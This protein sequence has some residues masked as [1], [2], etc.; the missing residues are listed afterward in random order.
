MHVCV[1]VQHILWEA[2]MYCRGGVDP[3]SFR[4]VQSTEHQIAKQADTCWRDF[5][6][7]LNAPL[8]LCVVMCCMG[9]VLL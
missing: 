4:R 8:S 7:W 5:V 9:C 3:D 1:K 2:L 6:T